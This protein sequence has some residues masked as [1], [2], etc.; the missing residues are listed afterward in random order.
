MTTP[1]RIKR[2]VSVVVAGVCVAWLIG[3][4]VSDRFIWSQWLLWIPTPAVLL[5]VAT[6][7]ALA[8]RRSD[9]PDRCRR[10]LIAW[11]VTGCV[12][13][14][15]FGFFEHRFLRAAPE[16]DAAL[17][18]VHASVHATGPR[19]LDAYGEELTA[20][21]GDVT[22]SARCFRCRASTG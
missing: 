19:V 9:T 3:R 8:F 22:S 2:F 14:V 20:L 1:G 15:F 17:R 21:G 4:I 7:L 16:G 11:G 18:L 6:V 10:R 13:F 5:A 12:L